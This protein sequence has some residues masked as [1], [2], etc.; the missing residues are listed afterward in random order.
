[1]TRTHRSLVLLHLLLLGGLGVVWGPPRSSTT[2]YLAR[3]TRS[4]PLCGHGRWQS[5][6]ETG[7]LGRRSRGRW[8]A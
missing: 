2:N 3:P 8:P 4:R 7:R 6:T 5:G 1:M